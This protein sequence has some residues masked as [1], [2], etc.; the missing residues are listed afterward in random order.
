M[1]AQSFL[2]ASVNGT[3]VGV[4]HLAFEV[5]FVDVISRMRSA[6]GADSLSADCLNQCS[7]VWR[8]AFQFFKFPWTFEL[9]Y[10]CSVTFKHCWIRIYRLVSSYYVV[11]VQDLHLLFQAH[12]M[13]PHHL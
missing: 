2:S 7:S 5:K 10:V 12:Q 4:G 11:H 3:T 8:Y 1:R 13:Y 6:K 9:K